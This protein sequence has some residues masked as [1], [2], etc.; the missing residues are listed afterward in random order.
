VYAAAGK[1]S[2]SLQVTDGLGSDTK[3]SSD[4]IT[5][6]Q[7]LKADFT[8]PDPIFAGL[9]VNFTDNSIG[10]INSYQWAFSGGDQNT[11]SGKSPM[12]VVFSTAGIHTVSLAISNAI[13]TSFVKKDIN[14]LVVTEI[15]RKD[16]LPIAFPNP[17]NGLLNINYPAEKIAQLDFYDMLRDHLIL[18]VQSGVEQINL[19]GFSCGIYLLKLTT[20]DNGFFYTKILKR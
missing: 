18:T 2:V 10:Q 17:T 5:V 4:Y 15:E 9:A 1:Y 13:D 20:T 7:K 19:G 16:L 3:T 8:V 6:Y 12:S 14:V 11:F